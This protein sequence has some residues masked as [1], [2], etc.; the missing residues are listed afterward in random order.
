[1]RENLETQKDTP[2]NMEGGEKL[3]ERMRM[4]RQRHQKLNKGKRGWKRTRS[5]SGRRE[6]VPW[7]KRQRE[8]SA[9]KVMEMQKQTDEHLTGADDRED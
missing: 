2:K 4:R 7:R 9:V 6:G 5:G 1:M 8:K 3:R